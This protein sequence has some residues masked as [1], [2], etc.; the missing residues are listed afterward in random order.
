MDIYTLYKI[1]MGEFKVSLG[2]QRILLGPPTRT[3]ENAHKCL[4]QLPLLIVFT[5]FFTNKKARA[6]SS[7]LWNMNML[8]IS[9]LHDYR[10]WWFE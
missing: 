10:V 5:T 1:P 4:S 2:V 9:F 3:D 8:G 7:C 6:N